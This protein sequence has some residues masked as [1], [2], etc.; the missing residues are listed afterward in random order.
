MTETTYKKSL[1]RIEEL[2]AVVGN[3]TSPESPAFEELDKLSDQV[4]AYEEASF[5][6]QIPSLLDV[7]RLRMEEMG[8]NQKQLAELLGTPTSRISEYL[9]GKRS[10]TLDVARQLHQKLNIDADIILQ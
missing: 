5:P 7:I 1:A 8:I 6:V 3:E 2:L 10:I 4:A 9:K